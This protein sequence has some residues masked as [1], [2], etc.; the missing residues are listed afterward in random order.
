V[1]LVGYA[2]NTGAFEQGLQ[3][4]FRPTFSKLSAD[5]VLVAMGHAFFTLSLGMGAVMVYGSYLPEQGLDRRHHPHHRAAD[6]LVA[7]LAAVAIFPI[8]FANGL[9][10]GAGPGLIFQTLPIAFGQMPGASCS[11]PCSSCC[12]CSPPGPRRSRSS[13]RRWPGWWRTW[14]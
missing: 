8:V 3:F 6:T 14:H 13:S 2:M 7:M 12:W 11:A 9:E 1:I 4:L 10:P 5:G